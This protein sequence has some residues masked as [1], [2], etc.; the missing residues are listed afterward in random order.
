MAKQ[1]TAQGGTPVIVTALTRRS[2][3]NGVLTDSLADV[4]AAA[5]AAATTVG[6]LMLDLN[7]ASKTYVQAIG[8]T[9]AD[10]YNLVSGDRTHLNAWGSVVFGRMVADLLLAKKSDLST[11]I[12][13]N[14]TM[15]ALIANGIYA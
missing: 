4:A 9:N 6:A 8:S 12:T 10:K 11:Y 14:A 5:K 1:V 3:S 15:T 2:F 13:P 7:L